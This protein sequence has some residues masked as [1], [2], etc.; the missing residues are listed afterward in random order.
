M[1]LSLSCGED[2]KLTKGRGVDATT[3]FLTLAKASLESLA[4]L[5]LKGIEAMVR[6]FVDD[7]VVTTTD[8]SWLSIKDDKISFLQ[9][10]LTFFC[11]TGQSFNL[12]QA[13]AKS[14]L[15]PE[16]FKAAFDTGCHTLNFVTWIQ[17]GSSLFCRPNCSTMFNFIFFGPHLILT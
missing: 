6:T 2:G 17:A 10:E 7:A 16:G 4:G 11:K 14:E 3:S 15:F 8:P 1:I 13:A 12:I 5:L 9:R